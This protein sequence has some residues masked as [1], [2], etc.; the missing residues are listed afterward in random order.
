VIGDVSTTTEPRQQGRPPQESPDCQSSVG[1]I[2]IP[3]SYNL[4]AAQPC[5]AGMRTSTAALLASRF[6]YVTPSGVTGSS[7]PEPGEA[8][9]GAGP[10]LPADADQSDQLIDGGYAEN[11]G[12]GTL[13]ELSAQA[14]P[15]VRKVN[16]QQVHGSADP[17]TIIVPMIISIDNAPQRDSARP[18]ARAPVIEALVPVTSGLR[19][20]AVLNDP[21]TLL[22]R[23][24]VDTDD[25]LPECVPVGTEPCDVGQVAAIR[26]AVAT[27]VPERSFV[28]APPSAPG[29]AA[30]LGWVMSGASREAMSHAL[31]D[32]VPPDGV[33]PPVPNQLFNLLHGLRDAPG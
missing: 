5:L 6:P 23:I 24:T 27:K 30:P 15:L 9:V 21:T 10:A 11:S 3:G 4:F 16:D 28:V 1:D 33:D 17:V 13:L 26:Q 2:G 19:R 20:G 7:C 32:L 18:T 25:W 31:N 12:I 29:V 22:D 8:V 14:M